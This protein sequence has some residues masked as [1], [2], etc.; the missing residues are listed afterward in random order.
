MKQDEQ[1]EIRSS[2]KKLTLY[3]CSLKIFRVTIINEP[4]S[5]M[6]KPVICSS[7]DK[8]PAHNALSVMTF[9]QA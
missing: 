7:Q 1:I 8:V 2:G 5:F 6:D 3:K 9:G 4:P